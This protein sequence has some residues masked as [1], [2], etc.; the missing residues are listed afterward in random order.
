MTGGIRNFSA[1]TL[2]TEAELA[3]LQTG[4]SVEARHVAAVQ[5]NSGSQAFDQRQSLER[6]LVRH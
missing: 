6:R 3:D 1:T 4:R 2:P 5:S